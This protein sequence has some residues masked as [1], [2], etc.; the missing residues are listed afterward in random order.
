MQGQEPKDR[1]NYQLKA[2]KDAVIQ[3]RQKIEREG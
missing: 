2:Q 3:V 1:G